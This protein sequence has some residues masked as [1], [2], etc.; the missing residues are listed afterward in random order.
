MRKARQDLNLTFMGIVLCVFLVSSHVVYAEE[1]VGM[2]VRPF[3][4]DP[5]NRHLVVDGI[6][7]VSFDDH[8]IGVFLENKGQETITNVTA[9]ASFPSGSG[10]EIIK[11]NYE[12]GDLEPNK[13]ALGFFRASFGKSS[14]AKYPLTL[15]V[16]GEVSGQPGEWKTSRDLFVIKS[17]IDPKVPNQ[18]T[19]KFP[20]GKLVDS[21]YEFNKGSNPGSSMA[22][23]NYKWFVEYIK[24]YKNQYSDLPLGD[25]WL[26]LMGSMVPA[27]AKLTAVDK[28]VTELFGADCGYT[29]RGIGKAAFTASA[30]AVTTN[31]TD[32]FRIGQENTHPG[33]DEVTIKEEV[34]VSM[35]YLSEPTPGTGFTA[36]VQWT[37]TRTTNVT[38]YQYTHHE[39]VQNTHSAGRPGVNIKRRKSDRGQEFLITAKTPR[40]AGINQRYFAANLFKVD[41]TQLEEVV[42]SVILRDDGH[43]GDSIA[44]DG[45]YTGV[46]A[47]EDLPRGSSL[48]TFVFGFDINSA[49]VTDDPLTAAAK[50]GGVLI[51]TPPFNLVPVKPTIT[52]KKK[53]PLKP[54]K[55]VIKAVGA[56]GKV[57]RAAGKVVGAAGKAAKIILKA[58][59][60]LKVCIGGWASLDL[61]R[62]SPGIEKNVDGIPV[63]TEI[64]ENGL[65]ARDIRG[66][67]LRGVK[68][69]LGFKI[70]ITR[71]VIG[72]SGGYRFRTKGT[73]E[74]GDDEPGFSSYSIPLELFL[75]I[76]VGKKSFLRLAGG[77]DFYNSTINSSPG[78]FEDSGRGKHFSLGTGYF[79]AKNLALTFDVQYVSARLNKFTRT[80]RERDWQL[81][82]YDPPGKKSLVERDVNASLSQFEKPLEIDFTG[83]RLSVGIN[84]CL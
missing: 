11:G 34:E 22:P 80:V 62:L 36:D 60:V 38:T 27:G 50:I 6:F 8:I 84:I 81:I 33:P 68:L 52:G 69:S 44:G 79:L 28:R 58:P 64:P 24:P 26:K 41:D 77:V 21:I 2:P 45:I 35:D 73:F 19:I 20:E 1:V 53:S 39:K 23:K 40:A 72:V 18:W 61:G 15:N 47:V 4:I 14:P 29:V 55:T 32:P 42:Q 48:N 3:A 13:P 78:T 25:P 54:E 17:E 30:L 57:V 49:S 59:L 56:A 9:A 46:G 67:F 75:K 5:V 70:P 51:S 65:P 83:L 31:S 74:I 76:P 7:D 71:F 12:F 63:I 16:S 37:Y 43:Q 10:I 66:S 82:I